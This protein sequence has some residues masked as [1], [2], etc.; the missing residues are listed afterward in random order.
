VRPWFVPAR[1]ALEA[2]TP[3]QL[4][5]T[6]SVIGSWGRDPV[7][8]D[9]GYRLASSVG[10][11]VPYWSQEKARAYSIN[12]YRANPMAKAIIDT[13]T[14]FCV[15]DSGV[16]LQVTSPQVQEVAEEFWNDPRNNLAAIQDLM[17][18]DQLLNG[19]TLL[20]KHFHDQ[21]LALGEGLQWQRFA[22]D[23]GW[24][25]VDKAVIVF[26]RDCGEPAFL[27]VFMNYATGHQRQPG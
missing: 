7:D 20:E 19:E 22:I 15:G 25:M 14:S 21:S 24:G 12:A 9:I 1:R 11:E 8:G 2:T 27:Q 6:G 23:R 5:A 18:R 13:Y 4:I 26:Q 10:R 16:S 3:D 17:L